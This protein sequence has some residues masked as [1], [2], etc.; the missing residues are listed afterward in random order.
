MRRL[1]A[2]LRRRLALVRRL[3]VRA[4]LRAAAERFAF[5]AA[6]VLAALRAAA[7]RLRLL[8]GLRLRRRVVVLRA[9]VR[10]LRRVVVFRL[11]RRR[12]GFAMGFLFGLGFLRAARAAV[13]R[14]L[15]FLTRRRLTVRLRADDPAAFLR[16]RRL[17]LTKYVINVV[18]LGRRIVRRTPCTLGGLERDTRARFLIPAGLG[19]GV[20]CRYR[21]L[22]LRVR[23]G[24]RR[25]S[26]SFSCF[27]CAVCVFCM[28][29]M[30]W[31]CLIC[32]VWIVRNSLRMLWW[33]L[34][35]C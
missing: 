35:S 12:F 15:S 14:R 33:P 11:A 6:R 16:R 28:V 24:G 10:R 26:T 21:R 5:L 34:V 17:G 20:K 30:I 3:R 27:P 23:R 18:S 31:R 4:A 1:R 2:G 22:R 25:S 9:V 19:P 7:V 8:D 29:S 32:S 13:L